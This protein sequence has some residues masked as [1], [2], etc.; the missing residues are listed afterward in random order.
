MYFRLQQVP[1]HLKIS[2]VGLR[3]EGVASEWYQWIFLSNRVNSWPEFAFAVKEHF[4]SSDYYDL[5]GLLSKLS[6]Q[7]SLFD[8]V[9]EF[10]S[11]INQVTEFSDD[12]LMS[13]LLLMRPIIQSCVLHSLLP[14]RSITTLPSLHQFLRPLPCRSRYLRKVRADPGKI[15]AMINWPIPG[16]LKRL[17]GFLGLTGYYRRFVHNYAMIAAPMSDLLKGDGKFNWSPAAELAFQHLK[18]IM[19]G[20]LVLA[21]PDFSSPFVL[22]TDA[23]TTVVGVVLCKNPLR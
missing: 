5:K 23:P 6:Q 4:G 11:L 13:L 22:E 17:R 2:L 9:R 10:E 16:T 1:E 14:L 20:T 19:T 21:L 3:M 12:Q 18:T 7:G 8:Y 15:E